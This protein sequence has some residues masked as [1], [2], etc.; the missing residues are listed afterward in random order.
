MAELLAPGIVDP[1]DLDYWADPHAVLAAARARGRIGRTPHG[2][3]VL[4]GYEDAHEALR[5]PLLET[6]GVAAILARNNVTEGPFHD[7][8]QLLLLSMR[9]PDHT[10]LRALVRKAFTARQVERVRPGT[11]DRLRRL[12]AGPREAGRV[13]WV[14][15]I[16]HELPVWVICELVGVPSADRDVIKAW[17]VDIGHAFTNSLSADQL[18]RADDAVRSLYGYLQTLI[19][20]RRK[21]PRDD[22]LS[23][24]VHAEQDGD[25]LRTTELYAI[26]ANLLVG[27]HN[28]TRGLLSIAACLL[29]QHPAQ[30]ALLRAGGAVEA[31]EEVL[32]YEAPIPS[33]V[34]LA[35]ADV[36]LA[37]TRVA[38]GEAVHVSFLAANRDP[39]RFASPDRFDVRRA[40][41]RPIS[42]GF[43]IHHCVGAA[44]ARLEA[45][46]A[47]AELAT[48]V[49][50]LVLEIDEPR[51]E[52]FLQVRRIEAVPLSFRSV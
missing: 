16:A 27:G 31:T 32:R 21:A 45:Q 8:C 5:H 38:A 35:R 50:E 47:I 19:I 25:R 14:G 36:S 29:A 26:V 37:G 7:W 3:P 13:E 20:R 17:T 2:E 41:V 23:A 24:L 10:R 30:F 46:E 48:T 1:A 6:F 15:E 4:L 43:G 33:T 12:L 42:F 9:P 11:R 22:L 34:R 52:P 40:D 39:A 28:T 18:R 44:L 49:R 51:W